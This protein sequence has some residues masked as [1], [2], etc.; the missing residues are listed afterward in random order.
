[1]ETE[2]KT[3]KNKNLIRWV[4]VIPL[5]IVASWVNFKFFGTL[6]VIDFYP[7]NPTQVY[8]FFFFILIG[9]TTAMVWVF[10]SYLIAPNNKIT[11]TWISYCVGVFICLITSYFV[12]TDKGS[13]YW[14]MMSAIIFAIVGGFSVALTLQKKSRLKST[15]FKTD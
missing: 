6:F 4:L 3:T 13:F 7:K 2:L 14:G 5:T 15:N 1:M 11:A 9:S 8:F 12:I 10:T